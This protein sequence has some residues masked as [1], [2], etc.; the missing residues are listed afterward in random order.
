MFRRPGKSPLEE[1]QYKYSAEPPKS[2]APPRV[3]EAPRQPVTTP[4]PR[5]ESW[6]EEDKS[7]LPHHFQNVMNE[8][9]PETTL[10]EGVTFRGE[11]SFERLLRID[12]TFEGELL[13]QGKV[14]VGPKGVVKAN[15]VLREAVVEGVIEGDVTVQEKLELR[16]EASVKGD[17]QAKTICVD[18]GVTLEGLIKVGG[19]PE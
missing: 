18:E 19:T 12:G 3:F 1:D 14:I 11:L 7:T 13:S 17:I 8:E 10:G 5:E 16:G 4:L 15:L 6:P 2:E 9:A